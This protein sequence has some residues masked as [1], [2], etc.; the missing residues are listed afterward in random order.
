M[1]L[2]NRLNNENVSLYHR[3]YDNRGSLLDI[4]QTLVLNE[5]E[6]EE[7]LISRNPSKG[8]CET[9]F[10][11]SVG[12]V[13]CLVLI[14][15]FIAL[16]STQSGCSCQENLVYDPNNQC[17]NVPADLQSARY[18]CQVQNITQTYMFCGSLY[19]LNFFSCGE[20]GALA[21]RRTACELIGGNP[22]AVDFFKCQTR[23]GSDKSEE[24]CQFA[25]PLSDS[26]PSPTPS[27]GSNPTEQP[28][29]SASLFSNSFITIVSALVGL[30]LI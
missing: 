20:A 27:L 21:A 13:T 17:F 14:A 3:Q 4:F 28:T 30:C 26:T 12:M 2:N 18:T 6:K 7:L 23:L 1:F 8:T 22:D 29:S 15:F 24:N 9:C 25:S 5:S 16:V 19:C 10:G 11:K